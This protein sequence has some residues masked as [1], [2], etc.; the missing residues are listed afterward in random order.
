VSNIYNN[1]KAS[2]AKIDQNVNKAVYFFARFFFWQ[3]LLPPMEVGKL[4][5]PTKSSL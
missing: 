2:N 1:N 3:W 5:H 4:Q